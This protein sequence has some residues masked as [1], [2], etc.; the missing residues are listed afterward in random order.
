MWTTISRDPSPWGQIRS[1][2]RCR[3]TAGKMVIPGWVGGL[4]RGRLHVGGPLATGAMVVRTRR[5]SC[6]SGGWEVPSTRLTVSGKETTLRITARPLPRHGGD[7][8]LHARLCQVC[9]MTRR[10]VGRGATLASGALHSDQTTARRYADVTLQLVVKRTAGPSSPY[11]PDVWQT[12]PQQAVLRRDATRPE[13]CIRRLGTAGCTSRRR[14][15]RY[16][17]P[18]TT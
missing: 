18:E 11:R 2:R 17:R 10:S 7:K 9:H 6:R 13:A 8:R 4:P 14:S 12:P 16:G 15:A 3:R 1:G 5:A